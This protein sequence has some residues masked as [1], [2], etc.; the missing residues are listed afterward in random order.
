MPASGSYKVSAAARAADIPIKTLNRDIDRKIIKIPGPDPGKGYPRLFSL[1]RV[2]EIALGH[3]LTRLFVSPKVAMEIA[4]KFNEPQR[5]R[6]LGGI[7][8]IGKT[9]LLAT[10]DGTATIHNVQP[11]GD[12]DSLL[13]TEAAIVVDLGAIIARVNSRLETI[14]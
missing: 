2:H 6:P 11:D 3:A 10:Q 14:R 5:G 9:V 7:F 12:I 8:P 13:K 4:A 1:A